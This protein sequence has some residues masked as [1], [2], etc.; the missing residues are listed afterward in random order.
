MVRLPPRGRPGPLPEHLR[1]EIEAISLPIYRFVN[2]GVYRCGFAGTQP[3]YDKAYQRRWEHLDILEE[4]LS[5][6]RYLVGDHITEADV[7]FFTTLVRFDLVYHGHFKRNR[8][9]LIEMPLW[10]YARDLFQTPGFGDTID[11]A[12]IKRHYYIVHTD[13]NPTGIVPLGPALDNWATPHGRES[14]GGSPSGEG[15]PPE[16]PRGR[17]AGA[18]PGARHARRLIVGMPSGSLAVQGNRLVVESGAVELGEGR[19]QHGGGHL[20]ERAR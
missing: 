16:P 3:A 19:S 15:T 14:L 1:D 13:V 9:K 11:F 20:V 17:P 12:H 4:H 10:G 5:T 7:R 8:N 18:Q 2:N 6:R